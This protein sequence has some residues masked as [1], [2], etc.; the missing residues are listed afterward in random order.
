MDSVDTLQAHFKNEREKFLNILDSIIILDIGTIEYVSPEGRATAVSSSFI[1]SKPITYAD[2]EVIYPGNNYGC[3]QAACPGMAC[4]IFLPKSCMPNVSNLKLRVGATSYNR[5][6]V[7]VM[8]IGNGSNNNV[9]TVFSEGGNLSILGQEYSIVYGADSVTFQREDG[10]TALTVDGT[11][12]MYVSRQTNTGTLNINIENTGVTK[13]WLSQNKDVLWTDTL[14]PDGSRSF[15]QSNPNDSEADPLFSMTIG[16]DGTLTVNTA[17]N[18]N[19]STTGDA[20]VTADG[21]INASAGGDIGVST[22]DGNVAIDASTIKLNGDSKSLVTYGELNTALSTFL[23]NLT[24]ALQGATYVP[25]SGTPAPLTWV[26]PIP[27]S[28]DISSAEAT[29]LKTGSSS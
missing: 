4:L 19:V 20:S 10:T 23:Q 26:V 15:V 3:H 13:T 27:T 1:D 7:K 16:A 8:P 2:A 5:D 11:G 24:L 22:D 21:N 29:T 9:S 17:S 28:I 18:I 14:N 12:Q 25:P 6:G